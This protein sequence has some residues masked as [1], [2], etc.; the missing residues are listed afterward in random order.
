MEHFSRYFSPLASPPLYLPE[1]LLHILLPGLATEKQAN[2]ALLL[3]LAAAHHSPGPV[4]KVQ[5]CG[6]WS[7]PRAH[8]C[9]LL[10]FTHRDGKGKWPVLSVTSELARILQRNRTNGIYIKIGKDLLWGIG[11]IMEAEKPYDLLSASRRP[12]KAGGVVPAQ[13]HRP[14]NRGRGGSVE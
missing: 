11:S 9:F 2:R 14:E 4:C 1:G 3:T 7:E 13:T 8:L 10:L 12:R 6:L 5:S